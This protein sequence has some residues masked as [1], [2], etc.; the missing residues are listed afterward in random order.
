MVGIVKFLTLRSCTGRSGLAFAA[1]RY[2]SP[3]PLAAQYQ[4]ENGFRPSQ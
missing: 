3:H 2:A 4:A 1:P